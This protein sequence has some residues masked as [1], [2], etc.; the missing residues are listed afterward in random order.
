MKPV[1]K[2]GRLKTAVRAWLGLG[3]E[4]ADQWSAALGVNSTSGVSVTEDKMLSL[5][6]VWACARLI[7]ET[8]ATLPLGI[9]ERTSTGK[10]PAPQHPLHQILHFQPNPDSTAA[11]HWE[12]TVAA[13]L[14]RGNARTEKLM[15]GDRVVGLNFLAPSR[16]SASRSGTGAKEFRYLERDGSYRIIPESRVWTVP[17]FS[18]DG[19]YGLSVVQYEIGRA[20]V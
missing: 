15:I 8:I 17:G 20:H 19:R 6:A 12:S 2:P 9:Y 7:S 3:P 13:M 18:L 5:S 14:L 10:R 11:V 4:Y 1:A 16:L